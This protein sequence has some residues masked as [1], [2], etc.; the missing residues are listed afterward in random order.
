M[1]KSGGN[2]SQH[3]ATPLQAA[4]GLVLWVAPTSVLQIAIVHRPGEGDWS[5]PKGKLESGETL[6]QC[7]LREV[8]EET[9]FAC[10]LGEFVGTT[11][12]TVR[13]RPKTVSYWLME[14]VG[15]EFHPNHEVDEL[16]FAS[17]ASALELLSYELDRN[18]LR[19]AA[20]LLPHV[21]AAAAHDQVGALASA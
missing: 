5:L 11:Q 9:G 14:P 1:A 17:F 6:E 12:Y 7:A 3:K 10:R 13:H 20:P 18:L 16:R 21:I 4:G 8:E 19:R 15:G 2:S